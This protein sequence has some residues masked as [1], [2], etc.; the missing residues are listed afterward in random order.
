M[1]IIADMNALSSDSVFS[2]LLE[3]DIPAT[4]TVRICSNNE[5]VE[6]GGNTYIPFPFK[7]SELTTASKGEVPQ[8]QI[9]IDNTSRAIEAYLQL[10]DQYLKEHGVAGNYISLTCYVVNTNDT[11]EAVLTEQFVLTSFDTDTKWAS[12]KLGAMSPFTMRYPMRRI[13]Q[14]FCSWKFKSE[15]C[16]YSGSGTSCDKTL[17]T[18]RSYGNSSRFGGFPGVGKGIRV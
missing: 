16:G 5:N 4:P 3:I 11:S 2:V 12:F 8:W 13:I 1:A 14:N 17:A 6:F 15:Q 10:Y 18:C 7:L 9:Q